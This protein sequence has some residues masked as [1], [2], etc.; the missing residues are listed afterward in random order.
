[1]DIYIV[2][3]TSG[4]GKSTVLKA[5]EDLDFYCVDNIPTILL[6]NFFEVLDNFSEN[7]KNVAIG[8]DIREKIFLNEFAKI[9]NEINLNNINLKI[10]FLDAKD[11]IIVRRFKETRR[12]HPLKLKNFIEALKF[13]RENL[14]FL[15]DKANIF[16]DTSNFNVHELKKFIYDNFSTGEEYFTVN[17]VSFG[18]KNGNL[19]EGDMIFDVRFLKNPYFVNELKYKSGKDPLVRQYI[20]SDKKTKV[21]IKKTLDFL[22][23][24][25]PEFK[26]EGKS[27]VVIGIGCT[28]GIH[29]SVA[30]AEEIGNGLMNNYN[31]SVRHR[32]IKE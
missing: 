4:A 22:N 31:V 7:I 15:K 19:I 23:F 10:I 26:N 24:L 29:R 32:D 8:V 27:Y 28:G 13:E 3:G 5:F 9:F 14:K 6:P 30:I 12:L 20:F 2:T 16:I 11:E 21:F 17:L 1:M 18:F 25:L